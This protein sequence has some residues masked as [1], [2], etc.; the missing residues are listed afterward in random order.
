M[1]RQRTSAANMWSSETLQDGINHVV[2]QSYPDDAEAELL[3]QLEDLRLIPFQLLIHHF[4]F[5]FRSC[6]ILVLRAS[7]FKKVKD[8]NIEAMFLN[9]VGY[10][11]HCSATPSFQEVNAE[12][13]KCQ[14]N[15][16]VHPSAVILIGLA[17]LVIPFKIH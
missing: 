5:Y 3:K 10:S 9:M 6:Q 15:G 4:L 12:I 11:K 14:R 1:S 17:I 7:C 8:N 13:D 16:L 2:T